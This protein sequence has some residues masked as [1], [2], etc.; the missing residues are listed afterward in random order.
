MR[1]ATER[2]LACFGFLLLQA[3][4]LNYA[5]VLELLLCVFGLAYFYIDYFHEQMRW[6]FTEQ[7]YMLAKR[8]ENP[9]FL[10]DVEIVPLLPRP[11]SPGVPHPEV[12]VYSLGL[13]PGPWTNPKTA[14]GV[15]VKTVERFLQRMVRSTCRLRSLLKVVETW[16]G[17]SIQKT[18]G[19]WTRSSGKT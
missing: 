2:I 11:L 12:S 10:G 4:G 3:M 15:P 9:A 1:D 6:D 18:A 19:I 17:G 7:H 16:G 8:L 14:R 13:S 5:G